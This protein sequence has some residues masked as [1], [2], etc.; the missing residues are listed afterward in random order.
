MFWIKKEHIL[1]GLDV[2]LL[3]G[4]SKYKSDGTL[5]SELVKWDMHM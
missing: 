2:N 3:D 4:T 1:L 5:I